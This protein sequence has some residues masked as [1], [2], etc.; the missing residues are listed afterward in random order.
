MPLST[1]SPEESVQSGGASEAPAA[2]APERAPAE[3]LSAPLL[4]WAT[5]LFVAYFLV[6]LCYFALT[7]SP[8]APPDEVTHAGVS[9]IFSKALLLPAN[10][11]ESYQFGLVTNIPWL[12]YWI[13]GKLVHLNIFGLNDLVFLR[14]V[15]I[16]IALGTVFY[17]LRTLRLLTGD[18]LTRLLLVVTLTN[19]L[20]FTFLS[21][22]VSYDNLTNLLSI[23]AI[24][25]LLAFLRLR[26]GNL[27]AASLLCQMAGCLTKV[28]FLPLALILNLVLLAA[29]FRD[30]PS[31]PAALKCYFSSSGVRGYA[32]VL[33]LVAGLALNLALYG[34]NY[35]RYGYVLPSMSDVLSPEV[36]W[37][38]R[39]SA[40]SMIFSQY[41]EG[42][43]SYMEALQ[44]T[45]TINHPGDKADTFYLLM[46]NENLKSNPGLMMGPFAYARLWFESMLSSSFGIKG[47]LGMFKPARQLVP[48]IALL[49][50]AVAGMALRWRPRQSGWL[51]ASLAGV[52]GI[53]ACYLLV[54]V[55]YDAYLYYGAPGMTLQGRY[56]FPVLGPIYIL[57]CL[58]LLSLFRSEKVRIGLALATALLF[59]AHDLPWFLAHV[60]PEWYQWQ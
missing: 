50:L 25:Y 13:M 20:M 33:A 22:S 42:K 12:Y 53:Y 5:G 14:L 1:T 11:P 28:S 27:L 51:P 38:H 3:P 6:R 36:A 58:Y 60:T 29:A 39:I 19:T 43:I 37:Q 7:I 9:M 17:A 2:A 26:S 18:R 8:F 54:R 59:L 30:I 4:N 45:G 40:R 15:N 10:S 47:H 34:G 49:A 56:L 46:T 35:L 52:A 21:A 44:L 48:F 41:K 55:N 23:M 31:L 57:G 24:Y 16:P 32:L